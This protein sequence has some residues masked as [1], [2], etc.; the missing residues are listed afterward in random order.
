MQGMEKGIPN[1]EESKMEEEKG[2]E[3]IEFYGEECP[4]CRQVA[5]HLKKLEREE[6]IVF[7]RYE[8][9]HD[10]KNQALMMKY[11]KGRCNGVPFFYNRKN[12]S[13]LCG[14]TDYD[15]IR[16]WAKQE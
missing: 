7:S 9:W 12:D 13:F 16:E 4:P 1:K 6:G 15:R 11:A 14:V 10:S 2:H 5:M 8:V 3:L